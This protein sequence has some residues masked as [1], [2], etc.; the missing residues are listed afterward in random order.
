MLSFSLVRLQQQQQVKKINH[1]DEPQ[2][3]VPV[4]EEK[5]E[6]QEERPIES[7]LHLLP[8]P[9]VCI[10]YL[11]PHSSLECSAP[12]HP[13]NEGLFSHFTVCLESTSHQQKKAMQE[14]LSFSKSPATKTCD[15]VLA[16]PHLCSPRKPMREV[17]HKMEN[18]CKL[19]KQQQC[20][21]SLLKLR[22]LAQQIC[23]KC[24]NMV[25]AIDF[26]LVLLHL[27]FEIAS[28][29]LQNHRTSHFEVEL[30]MFQMLPSITTSSKQITYC[31]THFKRGI[32]R[33]AY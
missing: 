6:I 17:I 30:H 29:R 20:I 5:E 8:G 23:A 9:E 18:M 19:E 3:S 15:L 27:H 16:T 26:I 31:R 33:V 1:V 24:Q 22:Q 10:P 7:R 2:V 28:S 32:F 14:L 4:K 25:S 13:P 21:I 12:Y 11:P